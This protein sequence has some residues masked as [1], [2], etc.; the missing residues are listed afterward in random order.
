M[1][2]YNDTNFI[3]GLRFYAVF[4]VF[5]A[6]SSGTGL[7]LDFPSISP[8]YYLGKYG[9]DIFF[10]ISGFTI[11]SQLSNNKITLKKFLYIRL[12][13]ISSA[14]WPALLLLIFYYLFFNEPK[15][16]GWYDAFGSSLSFK[17]IAAHF[18]YVG[19]IFPQFAN[20]LIGVEWSLNIEV[21]YY[22]LLGGI[23][24]VL[25]INSLIKLVFVTITFLIFSIFVSIFR[26]R[27]GID[28]NLFLWIPLKY[29]YMFTLGG[30]AF[31]IR[32]ILNHSF[33][34]SNSKRYSDFAILISLMILSVIVIFK[35]YL[36]S[37]FVVSFAFACICFLLLCLVKQCSLLANVFTNKYVNFLGSLSFSFYLLHYPISSLL[38]YYLEISSLNMLMINFIISSFSAY[39]WCFLFENCLYNKL[40]RKVSV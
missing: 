32:N 11:Y 37:S 24:Y 33:S 17:N 21:F 30:A 25:S 8:L 31:F 36:V 27:L 15:L 5:L 13:R 26:V 4:L 29:G 35:V 16:T 3:T 22:I 39:I 28:E 10:V 6:H 38:N 19:S 18:L 1:K 12:V 2:N 34:E 9:V 7:Y 40:K 20:S 23:Y 14:Y